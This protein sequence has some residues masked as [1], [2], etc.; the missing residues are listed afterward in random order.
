L[1]EIIS[2]DASIRGE[3]NIVVG[4]GDVIIDQLPPAEARLRYE[5]GVLQKSVETTWIKAMLEESVYDAA[6]LELGIEAR[7][8]AV[9]PSWHMVIDGPDQSRLIIP[10]GKKVKEI[11]N[12]ANRF[13]LILGEPGSG[14]TT[15]LAQ[16]ARDLIAE[17][18]PAF[19]QP[20]PVIFNLSTWTNKQQPLSDWLVVELNSRYRVPKKD[21]QRWLS[22]RRILPLLD[23]LDEVKAE[24][25]AACVEKINQLAVNNLQ[26]LVVCSR[27]K[28]YTDLN[29][30][31]AFDRAIYLQPLTHEQ[32][33]E[34]LDLAGDKLASLRR[35][36]AADET[37]RN[38]AQSPLI[39][40]IMSLAYQNASAEALSDP[41]LATN[42]AR[43]KHL[44]DTY[45][46]QMFKRKGD[47]PPFEHE[48]S[49]R[50]LAWLARNMQRHNQQVFLIESLQ[51]SWLNAWHW[52]WLY[53]F[54]SRLVGSLL[55]GLSLGFFAGPRNQPSSWW[56]GMLTAGF[57]AGFSVSFVDVFRSGWLRKREETRK[58]PRVWWSIINIVAIGL[59][60]GLIYSLIYGLVYGMFLGRNGGFI[61]GLVFEGGDP[62]NSWLIEVV[63]YALITGLMGALVFG[64]IFGLRG[65][66]Q[67]LE[68][69]IQTVEELRWA[70]PKALKGGL[71]GG[72]IAGTMGGLIAL[73]V[74][75][76]IGGLI[77]GVVG[78]LISGLIGALTIGLIGALTS[79]LIFGL[80]GGLIGIFFGGFSREIAES[81]SIPNQGIWLSIRSAIIGGLIFG[82][83]IGL[84]GE[85]LAMSAGLT[86]GL[87]YWLTYGLPPEL[88]SWLINWLVA[89]VSLGLMG[90]LIGA[91]WYG[92]IDVVQHYILRLLLV[93]QGHTP[94]NYARFLDY[95]VDRIF[96]QKVGGGYRFIHRLLLE[97]FA[98]IDDVR[99]L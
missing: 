12:E 1:S 51:P 32:V 96:L 44:F 98:D 82:L 83:I 74:N 59:I 99:K 21:G 68:N 92:G 38:L 36:L 42:K 93:I 64:L 5:L 23:G 63:I 72:L 55:V 87:I 90:G 75:G 29:V 47:A 71:M 76:L 61:F 50:R 11:F 20:V 34:Y 8:K 73:P 60:A 26:G 15:T 19:T 56:F 77:G 39:L 33:D 66:R 2:Q 81:K 52:Q 13:L 88:I 85:S 53:F 45:V 28:D 94:G 57:F 89:G 22:E 25:R 24:N 6:L 97:H 31:L 78:G 79:A 46:S 54:A 86:F 49:K 9:E 58:S 43:R 14:K 3:G 91:L 80:I 65:S 17:I 16:L 4:R 18:D 35:A 30:H 70:W 10:R 95:A 27:D 41:A 69:D 84:I 40:S 48:K 7:Q 37:L 62:F 67:T